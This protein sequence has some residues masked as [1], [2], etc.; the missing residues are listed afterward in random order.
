MNAPVPVRPRVLLIARNLPP[1]RGGIERLMARALRELA[2][3]FD[4][5]VVGPSGCAP[6]V[7]GARTVVELP[8]GYAGFLLRAAHRVA[9]TKRAPYALCLASSGLMAPLARLA[10]RRHHCPYVV[11]VHGLDLTYANP[12]YRA[13]FLPAV[14]GAD[15]I[16]ANSRHTAELAVAAGVPE[17]RIA[18]IAPGVDVGAPVPMPATRAFVERLGVAGHPLL[19]FV[20]RLVARKGVAEFVEHGLP[21]VLQRVPDARFLVVGAE[22]GHGGRPSGPYRDGI[23]AA[24]RRAG[25]ERAVVMTGELGEDDLQTAYAAASVFVFP[26]IA[27]SGDVEGFGMVLVEAAAQGTPTVAFATG[28][29]ADAMGEGAGALVA[30]GDYEGMARTIAALLDPGAR[31]AA[32]H[33]CRAHAQTLGWDRYGARLRERLGVLVTERVA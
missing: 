28:G 27:R 32:G 25:V 20:G 6:L 13:A 17:Q 10:A 7:H 18:V 12:L 1:L 3:G 22:P 14:R 33:A 26:G 21:R 31:D 9:L 19:L 29:V 5:D 23:R 30:A 24:A 16:V 4:C 8:G 2:S 15:L 11:W